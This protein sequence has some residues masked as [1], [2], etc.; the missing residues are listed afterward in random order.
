MR[1]YLQYCIQAWCS[2]HRKDIE[3]MD[4]VHEG[5]QRAGASLL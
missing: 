1:P 2:Q 5:A 4:R 3:L